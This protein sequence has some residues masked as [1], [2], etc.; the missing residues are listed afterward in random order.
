MATDDFPES[1]WKVFRELRETALERFCERALSRVEELCRDTS[2]TPHERYLEVFRFLQD[3]D[4]ELVR[5]F[6]DPR[7]SR[8][9][10][11][12]AAIYAADLLAPEELAR[13]TEKTRTRVE[14]L[15]EA[16]SSQAES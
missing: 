4:E 16:S 10:Y 6:D 9:I 12:L 1:D 7:R 14:F 3:R 2:R 8:M 15:A 13:F 11:Q 5:A